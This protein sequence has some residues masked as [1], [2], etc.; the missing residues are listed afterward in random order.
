MNSTA[1]YEIEKS[2]IGA[3][4]RGGRA[5]YE[6]V[7]DIVSAEMFASVSH[8]QVWDA[9]QKMYDDGMQIDTIIVG[10]EIERRQAMGDLEQEWGNGVWSGRAYLAELR[11]N[12]DPR[13]IVS[14][15]DTL[16][17]YYIK[18]ELH[19]YAGKIAYWAANGRR[20][21]DII[22]DMHKKISSLSPSVDEDTVSVS[23]A[24][25]EAYDWIVRA[26]SGKMPGVSSG[27]ID[28]DKIIGSF[29]PGNVY[30]VAGRPGAG[31]T[32]FGISILLRAA[33]A[34]KRVGIF[35]LEMS[36]QQIFM[37]LVAQHTGVDLQNIIQ[38]K[39]NVDEWEKINQA[40]EEL[41][42]LDIII[43]D[44]SGADISQIRASARRMGTDKPMDILIIDYIQLVAPSDKKTRVREQ[45]VSEISRGIKYLAG[46]LNIPIVAL[47][48]LSRAVEQRQ[49]KKPILADLRESGSIEQ[50]AYAVI[51]L[52]RDDEMQRTQ[53]NFDVAKHRNGPV[54]GGVF[55]FHPPTARFDNASKVNIVR[56]A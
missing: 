41:S 32:A 51:F 53:I 24:A 7:R 14:Y 10:D 31:K 33:L 55:Y 43:N 28:L 54:G 25:S 35:S 2:I 13:N 37:R 11:T 27:L 12:G 6:R 47:A 34:G 21:Q 16:N 44:K 17:D 29:L 48:Q 46:E 56:L 3:V 8:R 1:H 23:Q 42:A 39:L 26:S 36:S 9:I 19:E 49:S 5:A 52:Y 40:V 50:D 20:A 18:R 45:E 38:G 30:V 4:L 15:A 22:L